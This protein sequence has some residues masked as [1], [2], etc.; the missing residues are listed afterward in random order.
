MRPVLL[1]VAT[2]PSRGMTGA[3]TA[4]SAHTANDAAIALPLTSGA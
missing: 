2:A 3:T 4:T 1:L